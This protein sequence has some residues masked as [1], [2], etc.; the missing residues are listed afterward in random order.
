MW[1]FM[2]YSA[3]AIWVYFDAQKRGNN[4][5]VWTIVIFLFGPISLPIYFAKRYLRE[6]ET[7]EGGLGWNICKNLA[8]VWTV[9]VFFA[10]VAGMVEVADMAQSARL[11][12]E[13]AGV[14]IGATLG[15]GLLF[16]LWLI[17]VVPVT[18]C[19]LLLRKSSIVEKGPTGP[20]VEADVIFERDIDGNIA[21]IEGSRKK[22]TSDRKSGDRASDR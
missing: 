5:N 21:R 15:V 14:A 9:T 16:V 20:M 18:V 1:Y 19:G 10:G 4:I 12:S 11:E 22:R 8:L 7:R 2:L 6:G 3:L 13:Q 17:V